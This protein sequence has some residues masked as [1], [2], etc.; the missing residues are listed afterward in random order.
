MNLRDLGQAPV[1]SA[2]HVPSNRSILRHGWTHEL[3]L[4]RET[5]LMVKAP[6]G[7]PAPWGPI[8]T[9][10][11]LLGDVH[12]LSW[13]T[14]LTERNVCTEPLLIYEVRETSLG[15]WVLSPV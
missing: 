9:C 5:G 14:V 8:T 10:H 11:H 6:W 1:L 12:V 13:C 7:P 4:S 2:F 3:L 15:A